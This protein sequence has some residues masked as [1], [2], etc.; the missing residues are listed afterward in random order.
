MADLFADQALSQEELWQIQIKETQIAF[1]QRVETACV[2]ARKVKERK[3]LYA[4]WRKELGDDIAR[5]S[6]R[7]AEALIKGEIRR[8]RWFRDR[9]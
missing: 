9:V 6:A 4:K 7:F 3:A 2:L 1:Q 8:P 5:E